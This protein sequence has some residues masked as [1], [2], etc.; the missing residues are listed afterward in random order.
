M[1]LFQQPVKIAE[2]AVPLPLLH[3]FHYEV[4]PSLE[5]RIQEGSRVLVPFK[6]RKFLGTV[7][8]FSN[9]P[10]KNLKN[11]LELPDPA[12]L[13]S[14][15]MLE[16]L[17]RLASHYAA[18]LG[19]VLKMA[20]PNFDVQKSKKVKPYLLESLP[21]E[22][23]NFISLTPSQK[24]IL[25]ELR[26]ALSKD[27]FSPFLLHGVTGSG[28]TEIYLR[29]IQ[30][31]LMQKKEAI[32]LVP[33]ISLTPQ[34][35][36]RFE[37]CFSGKIAVL[38][39]RLTAAQRREEWFKIKN[40]KVSITIGARSALF[41][42][43]ENIGVIVIDEEHDSSFKQEEKVRYNAKDMALLRGQ[44]EKAVV[45]LGSATPALES[46]FNVQQ[47][48][49]KLLR[50]PE[51]ISNIPLPLVEIVDL[52]KTQGPTFSPQHGMKTQTIFS[53][54]L[55]KALGE[56]LLHKN[57]AILLLNR[58]GYAPV[59][60]CQ[61]CGYNAKCP[62]CSVSLTV[63]AKQQKL[64]CHYCSHT[65]LL[66]SYCPD[67]RSTAFTSLGLGTE[68][69]EEELRRVF[70]QARIARMDRSS[71]QKKEML[72]KLL[73][74]FAKQKTDI[75]IGTQMVAKGHDFPNVTLVGVILA[76][77]S[78]HVPDFRAPERTFQLLTQVAGRAGR[79]EKGGQVIIQT[80]NPSHYSLQF[81]KTHDTLGFYQKEI[82]V[83]QELQY[84][85]FSKLVHLK[86]SHALEKK[87]YAKIQELSK[88]CQSILKSAPEL[89]ALELLGPAPAPL[90]KLK[91]KYRFHLL[92]KSPSYKLVKLFLSHL[93][94]H[95]R[96]LSKQP[97]IQIDVDPLNLL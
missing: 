84:P 96:F 5:N 53:D 40:K 59:Q 60:L 33:E 9:S 2:V 35:L 86:A 64:I 92:L 24:K 72:S 97:S 90:F 62:H 54:P 94:K 28:K 1:G 27:L 51:R 10:H 14:T 11:I 32:V 44:L 29:I 70:P 76:D 7:V 48:K 39:S 77:I 38:H 8:G 78:L 83:R 75:L 3:T 36:S 43:F 58:R 79:G 63:Y 68:K 69:V 45:V 34:L 46:Y 15:R 12:P 19:E 88:I 91:D 57:Q 65:L 55:L 21:S 18:P 66:S 52:K 80:F 95:D 93:L 50:L 85:P 41:A 37:S 31:A 81:A 17:K 25:E 16:F 13:F 67:C 42:P 30:E 82:Q 23:K 49:I 6:N 87:G 74:D 47:Q 26:N 89:A 22:Q 20:I 56:T 61:E 4:P 71:T 73:S